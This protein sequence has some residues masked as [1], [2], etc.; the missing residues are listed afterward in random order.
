ML[1]LFFKNCSGDKVQWFKVQLP[2]IIINDKDIED[3]LDTSFQAIF[4]KIEEWIQAGSGGVLESV[5]C[6]YINICVY[7]SLAGKSYLQL[8]KELRIQK[9]I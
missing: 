5:E 7:K 2:Q 6:D 1:G 8:P 9:R 4:Y 3:N